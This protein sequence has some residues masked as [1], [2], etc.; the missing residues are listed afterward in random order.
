MSGILALIATNML[1]NE[2]LPVR[3][4]TGPGG[5]SGPARVD[6]RELPKT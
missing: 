3:T 2:R 6:I 4:A 5:M 1:D